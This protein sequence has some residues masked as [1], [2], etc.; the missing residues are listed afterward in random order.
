MECGH[1]PYGIHMA[2]KIVRI[3][4]LTRPAR[5]GGPNHSTGE[6]IR[7]PK[8]PDDGQSDQLAAPL[9]LSVGTI[10][11]QNMLLDVGV[12]VGLTEDAP[13]F[14]VAVSLPIRFTL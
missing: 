3:G 6:G 10:L 4:S 7:F 14:G 1:N 8:N 9:N 2:S 11:R 13:D 12:S 5:A